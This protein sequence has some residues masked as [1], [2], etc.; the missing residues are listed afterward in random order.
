MQWDLGVQG[1]LVLAGMSLVFGVIAQAVFWSRATWW[2][3]L[4]AAVVS[5]LVGIA[6]SEAWFGWAT[7]E[8]LQPNI[9]GLS[10]DEVLIG[11]VVGVV[12]VLAARF[13]A[14]DRM[15]QLHHA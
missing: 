7:A 9:D 4:V 12:I 10:F 15:R 2:V 14:R 5:F 1:V 13:L 11:Y 8:D 6:I 3:G